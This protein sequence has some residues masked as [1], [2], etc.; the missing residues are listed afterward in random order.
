M[1]KFVFQGATTENMQHILF[2]YFYVFKFL[3]KKSQIQNWVTK[4]LNYTGILY[5]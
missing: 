2:F 4:L 5:T 1:Q 3:G